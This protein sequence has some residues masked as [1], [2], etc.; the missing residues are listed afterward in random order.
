MEDAAVDGIGE[1]LR[2]EELRD[3]LIGLVIGQ[4]RAEQRLFGLEVAGR[5]TLAEAEERL[6]DAVH[7]PIITRGACR[8]S[9]GGCGERG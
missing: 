6:V 7:R 1:M 2:R 3:A 4:Q 9:F 5:Q 8:A